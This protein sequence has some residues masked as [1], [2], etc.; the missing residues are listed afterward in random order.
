M[1]ILPFFLH[2][3]LAAALLKKEKKRVGDDI[4]KTFVQDYRYSLLPTVFSCLM[5]YNCVATFS[6]R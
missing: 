2:S 6:E 1:V 4:V 5:K 3:T